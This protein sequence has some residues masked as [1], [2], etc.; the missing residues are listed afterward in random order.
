M[1]KSFLLVPTLALAAGCASTRPTASAAFAAAS[2]TSMA[3]PIADVAVAV[4]P[5]STDTGAPAAGSSWLG[6]SADSDVLL[7]GTSEANVGVWVDAPT[8]RPHHR[9]PLDLALVIDTSG[10]MAG[11]KIE[12]A[13][14]AA[15]TLV[16]SLADGDIVS[17]DAFSDDAKTLVEST[18]LSAET[19]P[20]VLARI[21]ELPT[22]GSTNMFDGLAL[23]ESHVARAPVTHGVRRVVMISDGIANVGPS[24]PEALGAL[25]ERGLRFHAQ[26]T[27]LGV[28]TDYDEKTLNALALKTTGRLYHL[29]EPKEMASLL[30]R[31]V[32]LLTSTVASDAFVEVVP[33]PGVDLI[34]VAGVRS[35]N[36][37]SGALKLPLGALFAGQHREALVRVRLRDTQKTDA[38]RALASVRLHFRDPD[39]GDLERVQEIAVRTSFSND[40]AAVASHS[41]ART[42]SITAVMEAGRIQ[43]AAAQDVSSG[44]MAEADKQLAVA[45]KKL[46]TQALAVRDEPAKHRLA[47]AAQQIASTRA[48]M[49][50]PAGAGGGASAKPMAAPERRAKALDINAAG[51]Q[52]QGF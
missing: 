35:E 24:S 16:Q 23:A 10:S 1:R 34:E 36:L 49:A 9:V 21:A 44:Q 22:S 12:N 52:Q 27:S 50:P 30:R 6:A 5:R 28:G 18:V 8:A 2:P 31:E 38:P 46:E 7:A 51:M 40:D 15:R 37:G 48:S 42:Q 29:A 33:A 20:R 47:M 39:D 13:K 43:V 14:N 25:A 26:V 19:R 3:T 4:D 45:Q 41:N 32:D 11:A 17:I